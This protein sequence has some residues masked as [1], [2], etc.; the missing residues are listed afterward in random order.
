M[1]I[2]FCTKRMVAEKKIIMKWWHALHYKLDKKK[3]SVKRMSRLC[4]H[5]LKNCD[6]VHR[7]D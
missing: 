4:K 7:L 5:V 2:I 1:I 3:N 6:L